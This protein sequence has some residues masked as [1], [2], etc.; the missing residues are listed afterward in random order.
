MSKSQSDNLSFRDAFRGSGFSGK[1]ALILSSWFG[2]GLS[3]VAPGTCGTLAAVPLVILA[4]ASSM[5]TGILILVGCTAAALWSSNKTEEM[6]GSNDPSV[7]V[8]DEAAGFLL[9]MIFLPFSWAALCLGFILFR[10]FDIL[11]PFP[12]KRLE[13]LGHGFG[14]VLDDLLAGLYAYA[15]ARIILL[16]TQ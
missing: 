5:A 11:K 14:I 3:P 13:R 9:T 6:L 16:I 1:I 12:I 2:T 15:A 8:I 7:V 10:F 4:Q